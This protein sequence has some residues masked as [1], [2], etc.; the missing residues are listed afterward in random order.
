MVAEKATDGRVFA[1][2]PMHDT[3][4]ELAGGIGAS[5]FPDA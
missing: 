2:G 3:G 5:L 1:A 4:I